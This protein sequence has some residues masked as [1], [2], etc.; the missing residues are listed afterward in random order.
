MPPILENMQVIG[1]LLVKIIL[2][3]LLNF[4]AIFIGLVIGEETRH[5]TMSFIAMLIILMW[6]DLSILLSDEFL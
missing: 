2:F 5:K 1:I 6:L 3:V 4:G